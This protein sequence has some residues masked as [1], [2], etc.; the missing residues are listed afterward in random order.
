MK[1]TFSLSIIFSTINILLLTP[2]NSYFAVHL[3]EAGVNNIISRRQVVVNSLKDKKE[4]PHNLIMELVAFTADGKNKKPLQMISLIDD[5]HQNFH[6]T[7]NAIGSENDKK[8]LVAAFK[9]IEFKVDSISVMGKFITL[10]FHPYTLRDNAN[11]LSDKQLDLLNQYI[12]YRPHMSLYKITDGDTLRSSTVDPTFGH[13]KKVNIKP[14]KDYQN[15]LIQIW[16]SSLNNKPLGLFARSLASKLKTSIPEELKADRFWE[17]EFLSWLKN[18]PVTRQAVN[19]IQDSLNRFDQLSKKQQRIYH[20]YQMDS[21]L[22]KIYTIEQYINFLLDAYDVDT[23]EQNKTI[24]DVYENVI[25]ACAKIVTKIT[26]SED[27]KPVIALNNPSP[28]TP[29]QIEKIMEELSAQ[30]SGMTLQFELGH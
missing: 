28:F 18:L 29:E 9:L 15:D 13:V 21:W 2:A 8:D 5:A 11:S 20:K 1:F 3:S 24:K 10:C 26:P 17:S 19:Q 22:L 25:A 12:P 16:N 27:R 23:A 6:M 7:L 4:I 30:Y 14:Q